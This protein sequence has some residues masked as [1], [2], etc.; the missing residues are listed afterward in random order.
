MLNPIQMALCSG[1]APTP[2]L[3]FLQGDTLIAGLGSY[4]TYNECAYGGGVGS[5]GLK[6]VEK[7]RERVYKTSSTSYLAPDF[8]AMFIVYMASLG[9]WVNQKATTCLRGNG[10]FLIGTTFALPYNG[11]TMV[12]Y[13]EMQIP[14]EGEITGENVMFCLSVAGG[15]A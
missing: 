14:A 15:G 2:G 6:E 4:M 5:P 9:V 8:D 10:I 1:S 3:T 13:L 11:Q 12:F 7:I